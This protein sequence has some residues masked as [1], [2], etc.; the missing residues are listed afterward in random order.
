MWREFRPLQTQYE[1][2]PEWQEATPEPRRL[3]WYGRFDDSMDW[4]PSEEAESVETSPL[5][6][7]LGLASAPSKAPTQTPHPLRTNLWS[8]DIL[9]M[10]PRER[11]QPSVFQRKLELDF[12]ATT[13]LCLARTMGGPRSG[14]HRDVV[15]VGTWK[16]FPWGIWFTLQ[17]VNGMFEYTFTGQ[18]HLNP[19][20]DHAKFLQ[21]SILRY[22]ELSSSGDAT[23]PLYVEDPL[24]DSGFCRKRPR[25]WWRP[26]V[27]SFSGRGVGRDTADFSYQ[28]RAIGLS[29]PTP[30]SS[31]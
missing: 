19:F 16:I 11:R 6:E 10:R 26:V 21:G 24:Q 7:A 31:S 17:D 9:W 8:L 29:A 3:L 15:G 25:K 13:G 18:L 27:G 28:Q 12:N 14:D 22:E 30:S 2:D 4:M 20:G 1:K 5:L 23:Q